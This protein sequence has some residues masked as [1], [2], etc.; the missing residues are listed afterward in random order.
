M[1]IPPSGVMSLAVY[2]PTAK[3]IVV[4]IRVTMIY[5]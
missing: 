3:M 5:Q 2:V 4:H 1:L